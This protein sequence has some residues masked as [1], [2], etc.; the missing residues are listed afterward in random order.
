MSSQIRILPEHL[1][2]KIAAGE[3]IERPASVVKELVENSLDA[4]ASEITIEV[5]KGGRR[6]IRVIDDG[7]GMGREDVFLCLER[8]ATSKIASDADLFSLR[9]LGFRG[10]A[11]PSIASV[12]RM[13]LRS[14]PADSEA[15]MELVIEGGDIRRAEACGMAVGTSIEVR[16]L[17]FR[18]PARRKFLRRDETE[19]SHIG[20]VVTKIALAHPAVQ[21]RLLHQGRKLVD[22]RRNEDL[23]SRVTGLLGRSLAGELLAV[24]CSGAEGRV[25]GLVGPPQ[26]SRATTGAIYT[27]VNG[28]TIRD[29]VVQHAVMEAYRTLLPKGRYPVVVLF[30]EIDPAEVD[31]NVHPTKH[32]VRFRHQAQVHDFIA[33]AIRKVLGDSSW[34]LQESPS[35]NES[36]PLNPQ[37]PPWRTPAGGEVAER[38]REGVRESLDRY[39]QRRTDVAPS[40]PGCSLIR[41]PEKEPADNTAEAANGFFSGL[42][43][44]G[45]YHDSYLLCQDGDDLI[46]IDQHAAHERV[47]YE[48]LRQGWRRGEIERQQLLFPPVME[49]SHAEADLV[50]S[51]L[52]HF[53]ELGFELEHFGG[54][55]YVLKAI[56][57]IL[58]RDDAET[59]VRDV[60]D[61][62]GRLGRSSLIDEAVDRVLIR[63][64]CH[65]MVRANQAL[66]PEQ[67][68]AL[69]RQLDSIDFNAQCPHGRPVM[70]RLSLAE[71]EKF[72]HRS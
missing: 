68:R 58:A 52:G 67:V 17:F 55:S 45:Q 26:T 29:R 7:C 15:G 22:V 38:C 39:M 61:E 23:R 66:T 16:D 70:H 63:M 5:E 4:G 42:R 60:V 65:S 32:E 33:D 53:S 1:C 12:S 71:V 24:D 28:R 19:L 10:E 44:I 11:L 46:L 27:F 48:R 50:K 54:N 64:A 36:S 6:L 14:R 34:L 3:V 49:F 47:G 72:F 13:T 30:V 21:F 31:V 43:Y 40:V 35:Q 51:H 25:H 56:P 8:H 2:N 37:G 41:M 59:L 69:M 9:T 57:Q 62:L 20:D 18:M